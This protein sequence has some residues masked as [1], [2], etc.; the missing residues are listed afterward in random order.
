MERSAL[1]KFFEVAWDKMMIDQRGRTDK[2]G[3]PWKQWSISG[4][5]LL[6]SKICDH[7]LCSKVTSGLGSEGIRLNVKQIQVLK[8]M[9]VACLTC[10]SNLADITAVKSILLKLCK[11]TETLM[12]KNGRHKQYD[13]TDLQD[14]TLSRRPAK[15]P[16]V[17]EKY[18]IKGLDEEYRSL[19]MVIMIETEADAGNR[20]NSILHMIQKGGSLKKYLGENVMILGMGPYGPRIEDMDGQCDRAQYLRVNMMYQCCKDGATLKGMAHPNKKFPTKKTDGKYY[21]TGTRHTTLNQ[22]LQDIHIESPE[23][24]TGRAPVSCVIPNL[25][26]P[27]AGSST[28]IYWDDSKNAPPPKRGGTRTTD[29]PTSTFI[30]KLRGD[31]APYWF[32]EYAKHEMQLTD[33]CR[34]S[35][36]NSFEDTSKVDMDDSTWSSETFEVWNKWAQEGGG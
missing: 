33:P 3:K 13:G 30:N 35:C 34:L 19:K 31:K 2:N 1:E 14:F 9:V 5:L 27:K 26:G 36:M 12:F 21:T 23:A 7:Y 29:G 4:T 24:G 16:D 17:P 28:V 10:V 25:I 11:D 6:K 32:N 20:F 18:K 8:T 22:L 15:E